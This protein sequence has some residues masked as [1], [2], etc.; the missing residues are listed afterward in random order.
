M[1]HFC[2]PH[3]P[4]SVTYYLNDT[5]FLIVIY[6]IYWTRNP[7]TNSVLHLCITLILLYWLLPNI[8]MKKWQEV[9]R[10]EP[11]TIKM[12]SFSPILTQLKILS[13]FCDYCRYIFLGGRGEIL[14]I[15]ILK[16]IYRWTSLFADSV[17]AV[18]LIRDWFLATKPQYSRIF[19]PVTLLIHD[20]L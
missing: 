14:Y 17:F 3:P 13:P 1:W 16:W 20:F 5:I 15:L 7:K 6:S 2:D 19:L 9:A 4:L 18:S 11:T 8:K 12:Q 10:L